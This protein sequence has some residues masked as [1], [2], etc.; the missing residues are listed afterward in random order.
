MNKTAPN[1]FSFTGHK[2]VYRLYQQKHIQIRKAESHGNNI[3]E[4]HFNFILNYIFFSPQ[5]KNSAYK[6]YTV[7][8]FGKT[9]AHV[10]HLQLF[11]YKN[12]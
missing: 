3:F 10:F 5:E 2:D 12:M 7:Y 4:K 9:K 11:F 8:I 6:I 1:I